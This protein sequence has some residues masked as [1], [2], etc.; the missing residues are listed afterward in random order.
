[1]LSYILLCF[2]QAFNLIFEKSDTLSSQKRIHA[3]DEI[4][5]FCV[6]CM[7]FDH[8]LFTLGYN[9]G[10]SFSRGMFDFF[11]YISPLFAYTFVLLC[12]IS[13]RLSRNNLLR[14]ARMLGV[15]MAIT[16]ISYVI[17][18]YMP[19]EFGILHM[20]GSCVL[21]Y[22][23]TE[24]LLR[25]LPKGLM[26][27]LCA[28]LFLVTYGIPEMKLGVGNL[29]YPLPLSLYESNNFMIFGFASPMVAY[30]D[31]YPLFPWL[32]AFFSGVFLGGY[33]TEGKAPLWMYKKRIPFF[34]MLGKNAFF[35]YVAHQPIAYGIYTLISYFG[36]I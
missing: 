16:F 32:F 22:A 12:G 31:Y 27:V 7:I 30:S 17:L 18:P 13:S 19:I 6:F 14:G 9:F 35:A 21:L 20:L 2:H 3:L 5:G 23:L 29:S 25:K 26:C 36:G 10:H 15:A 1:M 8:C 4:R 24:K 34:S 28:L 11:A 33:L